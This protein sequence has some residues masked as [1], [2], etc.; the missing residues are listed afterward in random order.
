MRT[1]RL[2]LNKG[3]LKKWGT[4]LFIAIRLKSV[5]TLF[6]PHSTNRTTAVAR[7]NISIYQ[8]Y[9]LIN[10]KINKVI[11]SIVCGNLFSTQ[12]VLC[13]KLGENEINKSKIN[14]F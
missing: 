12:V 4:M 1:V 11:R 13:L 3:R 2:I 5:K 7:R 9:Y 14:I 6:L 8:P 10:T